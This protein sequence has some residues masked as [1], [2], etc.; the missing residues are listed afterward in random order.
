MQ[1]QRGAPGSGEQRRI[2]ARTKQTR[3]RITGVGVGAGAALPVHLPVI[4]GS[5]RRLSAGD[6]PV[7]AGDPPAIRRSSAPI[8]R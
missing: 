2:G 3:Q 8:R 4:G 7:V 1:T 5:I 6:P